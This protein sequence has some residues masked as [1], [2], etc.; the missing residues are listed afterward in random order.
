MTDIKTLWIDAF[1][2]W[3]KNE[4]RDMDTDTR[5]ELLEEIQV[6]ISIA[7]NAEREKQMDRK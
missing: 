3:L 1:E 5:V 6:R 7:L 2:K 4:T